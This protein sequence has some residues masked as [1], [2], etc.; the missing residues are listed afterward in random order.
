M[1][2]EEGEELT[3][4][5]D[6]RTEEARNT[7]KKRTQ[8]SYQ[9]CCGAS[10]ELQYAF[11]LYTGMV[12]RA[13]GVWAGVLFLGVTTACFFD[14]SLLRAAHAHAHTPH[15]HTTLIQPRPSPTRMSLELRNRQLRLFSAIASARSF[16]SFLAKIIQCG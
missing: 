15:T 5:H 10:L 14:T 8:Q 6:L 7:E 3:A 4:C 12:G 13:I 11:L 1:T 9:D 2:T 16:S